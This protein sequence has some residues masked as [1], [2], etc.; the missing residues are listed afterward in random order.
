MARKNED[1]LEVVV[2]MS[3]Y[4]RKLLSGLSLN[5]VAQV[6]SGLLDFEYY[7]ANLADFPP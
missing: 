7:Q 2:A 4:R 1:G 3:H 5:T 6:K